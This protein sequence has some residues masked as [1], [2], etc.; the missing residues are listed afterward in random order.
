MCMTIPPVCRHI[1]AF[2]SIPRL[3]CVIF[4]G[5]L[6]AGAPTTQW[7]KPRPTPRFKPKVPT[8]APVRIT[9]PYSTEEGTLAFP[10]TPP[11]SKPETE[12]N[13]GGRNAVV[14]PSRALPSSHRSRA[15]EKSDEISAFTA[16]ATATASLAHPTASS[17]IVSGSLPTPRSPSI[18][19]SLPHPTNISESLTKATSGEH[20]EERPRSSG[21]IRTLTPSTF[22]K[23]QMPG[24]DDEIDEIDEIEDYQSDSVLPPGKRS[25]GASSSRADAL[26]VKS[27]AAP[28]DIATGDTLETRDSGTAQTDPTPYSPTRFR[29]DSPPPSTADADISRL[30]LRVPSSAETPSQAADAF[31]ASNV[32]EADAKVQQSK[33]ADNASAEAVDK[34]TSSRGSR[35]DGRPAHRTSLLQSPSHPSSRTRADDSGVVP[36]TQES[37]PS[38][39]PISLVRLRTLSTACLST[40]SAILLGAPCHE[41]FTPDSF[42]T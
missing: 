24:S 26:E 9:S 16:T 35:S 38:T 2:I 6:Q 5:P 33:Y 32:A 31:S 12:H 23:Y 11:I 7:P 29:V 22:R 30:E 42:A 41:V 1:C 3:L 34:P 19:A 8:A 36:E 18:P 37:A 40:H 28:L 10:Q 39:D 21:P 27:E 13:S 4:Q 14:P 17:P 15:Y 25:H 20:A